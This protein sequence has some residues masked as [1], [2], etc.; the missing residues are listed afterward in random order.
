MTDLIEALLQLVAAGVLALGGYAITRLSTWLK[1]RA[2]DQ[3]RGYMLA[4]LD[5]AVEYGM[6]EAR[7][8]VR[9]GLSKS[10]PH[11]AAELARDYAQQQ[12]PDALARLKIDTA[13][14]DRM[15]RARMP[16][17]VKPFDGAAL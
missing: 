2:D 15:V 10:S 17:P 14:L 11:L 8:R 1:L 12:V 4:A 7:R 5:R 13:G 9:D 3:V 16:L 6:T